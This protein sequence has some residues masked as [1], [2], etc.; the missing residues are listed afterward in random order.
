MK[1]TKTKRKA[2]KQTE[3]FAAGACEDRQESLSGMNVQTF[4]R[5]N[6][7]M[8]STPGSFD[9]AVEVLSQQPRP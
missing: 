2:H 5:N 8:S 4:S 6:I 3:L 9:L 1:P 7:C